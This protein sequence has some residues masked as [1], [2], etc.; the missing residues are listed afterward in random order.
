MSFISN[1]TRCI[2]ISY[3]SSSLMPSNETTFKGRLWVT[4][5]ESDKITSR[6][7][8]MIQ[9]QGPD[10]LD[11]C[12]N[13]T[14]PLTLS[15]SFQPREALEKN[16]IGKRVI[17]KGLWDNKDDAIELTVVPS[18]ANGGLKLMPHF[19]SVTT[20][21]RQ[22][23]TS[24]TGSLDSPSL[25][26]EHDDSSSPTKVALPELNKTV[27]ETT[28]FFEKATL[29]EKGPSLQNPPT[30][31]GQTTGTTDSSNSDDDFDN[32]SIKGSSST[33]SLIF[34]FDDQDL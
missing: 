29:H 18:L 15:L 33:E 20:R 31:R 4:V 11:E 22:L 21:L 23:S 16:L 27:V 8:P 1:S 26:F 28:S 30:F 6:S 10:G 3:R 5:E 12:I 13:A 32:E 9:I 7:Y 17:A 24:S 25:P 34:D 14:A 2:N 19:S